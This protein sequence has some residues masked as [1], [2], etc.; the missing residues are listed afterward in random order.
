MKKLFLFSTAAMVLAI[1]SAHAET[2]RMRC[3]PDG[4]VPYYVSYDS[5]TGKAYV[6]GSRTG[7]TRQYHAFDMKRIANTLYVAVKAPRQTR[8]LY[9]AFG[10]GKNGVDSST[11]RAV[12]PGRSDSRDKCALQNVTPI[13]PPVA[14]PPVTPRNRNAEPEEPEE[15]H[16]AF[17]AF[18]PSRRSCLYP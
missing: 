15:R 13:I 4:S 6:T 2:F 5:D 14:P 11:L 1:G 10:Y 18:W 7:F 17:L 12:D 16:L 8:V 3:A 9:L